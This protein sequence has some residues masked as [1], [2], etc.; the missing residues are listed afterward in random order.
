MNEFPLKVTLHWPTALA[1][2]P[3]DDTV[4]IVDN[5]M[6]LK[7]TNDKKVV[8]V[9]GRP[10]H[11]PPK[12]VTG[13][14]LLS[15]EH[16]G[17]R[18]ATEVTLDHLQHIS[19][20][21]NGD[22]YLVE[23]DGKRLNQIR[24]VNTD[25]E[26][27]HY[28]GAQSRCDCRVEECKC[29][30]PKEEL[31]VNMLLSNPTA[32]TITPDSVLHIA[33]MG[34]LRIHSVLAALPAPDRLGQYEVLYP[35]TQ[36]LYVFNRFGQHVATKSLVTDRYAYNFTYNVNSYY[37]KL[38]KVVDGNGSMIV[39]R[40]DYKLLAK[41]MLFLNRR[42]CRFTMDNMGQLQTFVAA[43][44]FTATFSYIGNSG[45]IESKQTSRGHLFLYE[46]DGHGRLE[47]VTHPTGKK[48]RIGTDVDQSGALVRIDADSRSKVTMATNRNVLS[49][50]HGK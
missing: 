48:T 9:A 40:R 23:S 43:D 33:D 17:P 36:D 2:N 21:P 27:I 12:N 45:L 14:S 1:V 10:L 20:A 50:Q 49:L 30:N 38:L 42:I 35:Q 25:G 39:I 31:A 34:N 3:L 28:A 11:C 4:H 16:T 37:A 26:I 19:F 18:L 29:F 32:V 24:M 44:N 8:I 46:Y 7:V 5:N 41:E 15:E 47:A 13:R 6:I 22:L